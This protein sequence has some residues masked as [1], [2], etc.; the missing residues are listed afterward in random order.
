MKTTTLLAQYRRNISAS[1]AGALGTRDSVNLNFTRQLND[2]ISAGL[3]AS[4]YTTKDLGE[5]T[6][7]LDERTYLQLRDR[8]TWHLSQTFSLETDYR[9]TFI[10][11]EVLLE[12]ANSNQ[13][14]VWLNWRPKPM[15]RSR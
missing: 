6:V 12:S 7:S 3:G 2:R 15:V 14:T 8:F 11:R 10:D 9:Y 13:V 5:T 1:G 4:Y